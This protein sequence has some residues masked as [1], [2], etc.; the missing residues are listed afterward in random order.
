MV[1]Y[2]RVPS[3]L[4]KMPNIAIILEL[5]HNIGNATKMTFHRTRTEHFR[6]WP[7]RKGSRVRG[8]HAIGTLVG[9]NN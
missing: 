9:Q 6:Q 3:K 5:K 8:E 4:H 2:F 1:A 7:E